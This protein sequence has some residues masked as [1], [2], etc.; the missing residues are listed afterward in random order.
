MQVFTSKAD[1]VVP[2]YE[3]S[4]NRERGCFGEIVGLDRWFH[5]NKEITTRFRSLVADVEWN[6]EI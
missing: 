3:W 1:Q 6:W 4:E 5:S 2:E